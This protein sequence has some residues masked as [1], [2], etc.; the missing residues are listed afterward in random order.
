MKSFRWIVY[1]WVTG[2][3]AC[4]AIES[5]RNLTVG[6]GFVNPLGF[7]DATPMFS[8]KLPEGVTKQ[9]A[10]QLVVE[11]NGKPVWDSGWVESDQSVLVPYGGEPFASRDRAEWRV[12]FRDQDGTE[13]DW[14]D[15]ARFE[16]GL[17]SNE[18]WQAQ[19]IRPAQE[20]SQ[21]GE[22]VAV[23]RRG[24]STEKAIARARIYVTARGLFEL[25]L[26]GR[27]VGDDHFANGFTDYNQRLDTLTYDVTGQLRK[28]DNIL[29]AMLGT[30]WYAGRLP[31]KAKKAGPYGR[32]Q[33]LLLQLEIFYE[34]GSRDTI[35]SDGQWEGTFEGPIVSSSIYD[36]EVY[37]ARIKPSCW[38]PVTANPDLGS[39]RLQPKPF[40]PVRETQ[41]LAV[42]AI[43]EPEPG[44]FVFDLGQNM[45]GWARINVPVEKDQT[46]TIRFCRNAQSGRHA[47]YGKLP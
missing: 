28:G 15:T 20:R 42:Q 10:Y 14:S 37:D 21:D 29:D 36:G 4:Q 47:L 26:N 11:K 24:F 6:E 17:L 13:S 7:H 3:L 8:W 1:I 45:V 34:D 19:W 44:R 38:Q 39:A 41:A 35:V 18:D 27:R 16:L 43:T 46:V 40:A 23:L 9:T 32:D 25:T 33:E 2:V 12:R 5:P 31:F 30:G 22:P